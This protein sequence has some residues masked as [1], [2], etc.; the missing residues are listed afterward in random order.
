MQ[1]GAAGRFFF[2]MEADFH[3]QG[4]PSTLILHCNPQ[5]GQARLTSGQSNSLLQCSTKTRTLV[6]SV[7]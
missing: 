3:G 2:R 5:D 1:Q 7:C 6:F 4:I